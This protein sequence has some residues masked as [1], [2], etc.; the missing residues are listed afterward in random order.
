MD[1]RGSDRE[2]RKYSS[3]YK[4]Q[5]SSSQSNFDGGSTSRTVTIVK[6]YGNSQD[7]SAYHKYDYPIVE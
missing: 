1:H 3:P 2:S 7:Y 4:R 6:G 5:R